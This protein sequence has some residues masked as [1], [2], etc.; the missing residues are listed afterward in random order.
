[1]KKTVKSLILLGMTALCVCFAAC[2]E[3]KV[4]NGG[5][6]IDVCP[7]AD[8]N[9]EQQDCGD[10]P[11]TPADLDTAPSPA[12]GYVFSFNNVEVMIDAKAADVVE[13][14]GTYTYFEAPSCAFNGL[15]KIYTYT[16]FE[17]DTYPVDDVDYISAIVFR[18]DT[19]ETA[20]GVC[21]GMKKE[22]VVEKY[23]EPAEESG[24][25]A[26]Y[27]KDCMQLRFIYDDEGYVISI[28]YLSYNV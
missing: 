22:K 21:I 15:D 12:G 24:N 17:I 18:D 11:C 4:N 27:E 2:G 26:T 5:D 7:T 8:P 19:V 13:K 3:E 14:L 28:Q 16:S 1:M 9:E 25:L 6:D 20:E 10:E 23:G